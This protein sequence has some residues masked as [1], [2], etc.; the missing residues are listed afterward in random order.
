MRKLS[1]L[2]LA[3]VI[4]MGCSQPSGKSS[5]LTVEELNIIKNSEGIMRVLTTE[6]P[7]DMKVLRA[8][9]I[10][11]PAEDLRLEAYRTLTDLMLTTVTHPSQDGVG[12]AAPQVGLNRRV[13]AV[14]RFDKEGA[15][16]EV[17]PN[18]RIVWASDSLNAGL[19]GC[20]SVPNRRGEV[21]RSQE[22]IIEYA[23]VTRLEESNYM[24]RDTVQNFTAVI[25]QHEID[26]LEG[27]L[28]I[29]KL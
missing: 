12:I 1:Y 3:F 4:A 29:D 27:I 5:R 17:Y 26:H 24:V 21:M 15:P 6:S 9:S 13:V 25:F 19:E 16:F 2:I 18:I 14:Q 10:D 11:I 23:D 8:K 20:L 22:I 28:Y 7:E